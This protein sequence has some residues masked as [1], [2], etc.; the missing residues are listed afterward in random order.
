VEEHK[1]GHGL[2]TDLGGD[3][4]LG[5]DVNLVEAELL[6]GRG[7]RDLLKDGANDLARTAPGGPEVDDDGLVAFNL[8]LSNSSSA[9]QKS[10]GRKGK[11]VQKKR[12]AMVGQERRREWIQA[13][14]VT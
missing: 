8:C 7:V 1:G 4:L 2:D 3:L 9:T 12:S 14:M 13:I 5:V 10:K 11:R 6:T